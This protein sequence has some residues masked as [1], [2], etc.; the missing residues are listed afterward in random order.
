M[1]KFKF[2]LTS[3]II[4]LLTFASCEYERAATPSVCDETPVLISLDQDNSQLSVECGAED[5]S[6]VIQSENQGLEFSINGEN[7]NTS[8][9]FEDLGAGSYS[10]IARTTSEGCNSEPL[11]VDITNENGLT[12]SLEQRSNADCGSSNGSISISQTNGA[13]PV[14]YSLNGGSFQQGGEFSNLSPD[15]YDIIARDA[16]GCEA[17]ISNIEITTGVSLSADIQPIIQ[18]NCAVT[19]C[20]SGSQPPNFSDKQN[21]LNNASRIKS[22]TSA[23]TMPPSGREDLTEQEIALIACWVDD[24]ALDN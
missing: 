23:E 10:I 22:R 3:I 20:H 7:F 13:E 15:S 24:G 19:G 5:G 12:I 6:I 11:V 8:A 4:C 16:N 21:I 2:H 9:S 17:S 14:S 1:I 18:N